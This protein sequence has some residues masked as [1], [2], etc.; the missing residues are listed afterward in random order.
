MGNYNI[1]AT[2][3]K[4][5]AEKTV[6]VKPYVLPK[7]KTTVTADKQ[8]YMPKE[9]VKAELQSD[10]FFGKPVAKAKVKVTASTF[11]VAFKDFATWEGTTNERGH[12][13]FEVKLPNYFV[14]QPLAKG[15]ALVRL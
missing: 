8:F 12:T 4:H 2:L 11:D 9:V 5:T 7:F 14:G 6:N 10:Y 15:N 3:G 13:K 1:R